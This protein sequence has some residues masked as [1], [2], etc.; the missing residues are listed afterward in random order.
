MAIGAATGKSATLAASPWV[1]LVCCGTYY[2]SI[3]FIR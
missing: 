3:F 1:W 2:A